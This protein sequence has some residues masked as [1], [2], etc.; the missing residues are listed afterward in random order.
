MEEMRQSV[1]IVHQALDR[2]PGGDV[3]A[4][5]AKYIRPQAGEVYHVVESPRGEQ[6]FYVVA[7]GGEMPYR[8]R[9]RAPSFVNLQALPI[10]CRGRLVADVIA[11]IGSIDIVL[12]DCDR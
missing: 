12:G 3:R 5:V 9:F 2:M 6:G 1:R 4:K 7:Q 11:V 8:V 10:M